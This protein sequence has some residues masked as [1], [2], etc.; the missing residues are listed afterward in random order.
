MEREIWKYEVAAGES[1]D[2]DVL[3]PSAGEII[4]V[5]TQEGRVYLWAIVRPDGVRS[6][7]RFGYF[8]TGAPIPE[9]W[10]YIGT[11]HV[12]ATPAAA[13]SLLVWHVFEDKTI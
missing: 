13:G 4:D 5:G 1:S 9:G 2:G 3:M 12:L 6:T 11:T 7:R 10:G 8:P